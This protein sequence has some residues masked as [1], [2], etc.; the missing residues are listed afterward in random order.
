MEGEELEIRVIDKFF[1]FCG[2]GG[3]Q[4]VEYGMKSV[5]GRRN[6]FFRSVKV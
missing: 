2:K 6:G 1:K 4:L 5:L 3:D